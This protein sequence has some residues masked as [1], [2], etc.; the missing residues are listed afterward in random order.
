MVTTAGDW[1]KSF[2][3]T[4][5]GVDIAYCLQRE[6]FTVQEARDAFYNERYSV[7]V[8]GRYLHVSNKPIHGGG[9]ADVFLAGTPQQHPCIRWD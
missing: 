4:D 3:N 7:A 1:I 2:A 6:G 5:R 8:M 9:L